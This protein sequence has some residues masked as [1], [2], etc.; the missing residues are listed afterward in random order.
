MLS[1]EIFSAR[2]KWLRENKGYTQKEMAEKL[3]LSQQYYGRFEKN[4]GEPSLETLAKLAKILREDA[5]FLIGLTDLCLEAKRNYDSFL[6][7]HKGYIEYQNQLSND[8]TLVG[9]LDDEYSKMR[10]EYLKNRISTTHD[11]MTKRHNK[12]MEILKE[13]PSVKEETLEKVIS[14]QSID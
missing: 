1:L 7:V 14:Y 10:M 2:L 8:L 12:T 9:K 6:I 4:K 3:E 13:T 5:N 11:V